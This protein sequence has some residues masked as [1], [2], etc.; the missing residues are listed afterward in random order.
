M[1]SLMDSVQ[2]LERKQTFGSEIAAE[3]GS[4][5][6][7]G[8]EA[9]FFAFVRLFLCAVLASIRILTQT[10]EAHLA[11][12]KKDLSLNKYTSQVCMHVFVGVGNVS[13]ITPWTADNIFYF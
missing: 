6:A 12:S 3:Q 1:Q 9:R 8:I 5:Q 2:V 7:S 13:L 10:N 11:P 4:H